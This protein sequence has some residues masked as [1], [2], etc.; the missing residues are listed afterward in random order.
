M[1]QYWP[2]VIRPKIIKVLEIN[3]LCV[4]AMSEEYI[5]LIFFFFLDVHPE[6]CDSEEDDGEE[7]N[8]R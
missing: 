5:E 6:N 4:G 3:S 2:F 1:T 7:D 8:Q